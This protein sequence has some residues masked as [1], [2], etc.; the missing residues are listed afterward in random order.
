MKPTN[1]PPSRRREACLIPKSM[2]TH[3]CP[4]CSMPWMSGDKSGPG[5]V[6]LM[7]REG[8]IETCPKCGHTIE[9]TP[10]TWMLHVDAWVYLPKHERPAD[11]FC[12]TDQ[13][14]DRMVAF[15]KEVA[16]GLLLTLRDEVGERV[17]HIE[18]DAEHIAHEVYPGHINPWR[19]R[20]GKEGG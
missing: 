5:T 9:H 13:E 3:H 8:I 15:S 16:D 2:R 20:R 12:P 18:V 4:P 10:H 19:K 11:E 6:V 17:G 1:S 14:S 7:V